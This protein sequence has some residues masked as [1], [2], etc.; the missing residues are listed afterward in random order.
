[1]LD[2]QHHSGILWPALFDQGTHRSTRNPEL[3]DAL[4][5]GQLELFNVC[6]V[7]RKNRGPIIKTFDTLKMPTVA[8]CSGVVA[9]TAPSANTLLTEA[10]AEILGAGF[11]Q[12]VPFRIASKIP[13]TVLPA[14]SALTG[15][16]RA[17]YSNIPRPFQV[18]TLR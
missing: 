18:P 4:R 3:K 13:R 11:V 1:M 7:N 10:R 5:I 14:E 15:A 9:A 2:E 17:W 12:V 8:T 6:L 16:L